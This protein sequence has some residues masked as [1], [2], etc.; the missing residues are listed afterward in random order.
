[1]RLPNTT[2]GV[3]SNSARALLHSYNNCDDA[4]VSPLP[5]TALTSSSELFST[6]S[7]SFAKLNRRDGA[8]G[9][10]PLDSNEQQWLQVDL[11]DRVEIVAVATQGRYGSSDWV[12]SYTLMF[13][14]TG[15]NWKQ[16][17]QDDTIWHVAG[18]SDACTGRLTSTV[19]KSIAL[20]L[21][22]FYHGLI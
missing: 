4:L 22:L 2:V 6:H 13:S 1:E 3:I 19:L 17:R 10:S 20:P 14:D 8:G 15:R 5:S 18:S 12:T 21:S 7:P 11:G 16:Y 9:W